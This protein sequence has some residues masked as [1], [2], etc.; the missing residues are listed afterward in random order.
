MS[1]ISS[2]TQFLFLFFDAIYFF[3]C[4]FLFKTSIAIQYNHTMTYRKKKFS[5]KFFVIIT[6]LIFLRD[7]L[8]FWSLISFV[9]FWVVLY[10]FGTFRAI[11]EKEME[12][13]RIFRNFLWVG[14]ELHDIGKGQ[15]DQPTKMRHIL[16][17]SKS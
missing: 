15:R 16:F 9:S 6:S 14:W 1:K 3:Y 11:M 8:S 12:K 10:F 2:D 17:A 5:K 7:L 13:T 4:N